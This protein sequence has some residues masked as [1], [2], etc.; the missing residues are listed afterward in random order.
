M[1]SAAS[2]VQSNNIMRL[3]LREKLSYASGS[4][5]SN[6][7]WNMVAGF[8]VVYYTDTAAIPAAL[9]G[10][11]ILVTRVGDAIFDPIVGVLVDR[12]RTRFGKTRPYLLYA[13]VPFALTCVLVFS[14]P[15]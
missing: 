14:V 1:A 15:A 12:T 5:A 13:A 8:L 2:A 11:L 3:S 4:V 7:S 10:T 9:V 6:L